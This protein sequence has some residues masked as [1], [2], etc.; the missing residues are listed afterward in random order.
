LPG[1]S[2]S[3]VPA[4]DDRDIA[5]NGMQRVTR[6][7]VKNL[8]HVAAVRSPAYA[9]PEPLMVREQTTVVQSSVERWRA[10]RASVTIATEQPT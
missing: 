10:W 4:R 7:L 6:R 9:S 1:L 2:I 8:D 5:S 3:F